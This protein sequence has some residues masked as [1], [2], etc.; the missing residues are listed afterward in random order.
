MG[1]LEIYSKIPRE[2]IYQT[3]GLGKVKKTKSPKR[4]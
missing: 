1:R 4:A 2:V 3:I